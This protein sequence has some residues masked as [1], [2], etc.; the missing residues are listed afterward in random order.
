VGEEKR[1]LE[2]QI[3]AAEAKM[4]DMRDFQTDQTGPMHM[5]EIENLH[6]RKELEINEKH[7]SLRASHMMEGEELRKRVQELSSTN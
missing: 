7:Q 2:Q 1:R 6:L 4:A 5:L 3:Q